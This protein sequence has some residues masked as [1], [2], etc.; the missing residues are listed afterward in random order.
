MIQHDRFREDLLDLDDP[1]AAS[2]GVHIAGPA[3]AARVEDNAVVFT[4]PLFACKPFSFEADPGAAQLTVQLRVQSWDGCMVRAT[5]S[6]GGDGEAEPASLDSSPMIERDPGF[7]P[8]R[9]TVT[10]GA[11]AGEYVVRDASGR[12]AFRTVPPRA[13]SHPWSR[14]LPDPAPVFDAVVVPDARTGVPFMAHDSFFPAHRES[15]GLGCVTRRGRPRLSLFSLH[16]RP[17]ERFLGTGERFSRFGLAGSTVVLENTDALGVSSRRAYKNVPFYV[18][19]AGYGLFIHTSYRTRL[20]FADVSSRAVQGA[21][22]SPVL[23]L[24]F[25]GG[26]VQS[27]VSTYRRL[28]GRPPLPPLWSYGTWMARMTYFSAEEVRGVAEG[29]RRGGFPCDVI[30]LDTGWFR[31]DWRCEWEFSPERFPD[32]EGFLRDMRQKGFRVS[33]WQLPLVTEG[34]SLFSLAREKQ[35]IAPGTQPPLES[36]FDD[37]RGCTIDFT[38]PDAVQW[39]KGLLRRLLTMGAAAIKTDFGETID[40]QASYQGMDAARLRNIYCLLYHRAAFEVTREVYPDGIIWARSGWAGS[41]RYPVHWGGDAAATWDG[42]AATIRGGLQIGLSGFGFWS[43]DVPG[44]HSLPSFMNDRPADDLFVRWTQVGVFTS[45]LRFH[46]SSAREPWEYPAVAEVVRQWL[47]L[48]YALIPYLL[49]EARDSAASGLPIF[50]SLVFHHDDDPIAWTV[51]DEF[52]CGSAFLVAPILS[53]SGVRSVYLPAGQWI[54]FWTGERVRG[55]VMLDRVEQPLERVPLYV[56][57]GSRI[58]FYPEPVAC[59]DEM[60]LSRTSELIFDPRYQ[61]FRASALAAHINL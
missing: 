2:D 46:G 44:F 28:T 34:T 40:M 6:F 45:H 27:I 29:M 18:S 3:T 13:P 30:H 26:S 7:Q 8:G 53:A 24:F 54:D 9:V 22:E 39:Y 41:Q 52:Y 21:V 5:V 61:G 32:P 23:D 43:H 11:A 59:T 56:R 12:A 55:P 4:V 58:P 17:G 10:A 51:E 60:D 14:Q 35:Y 57:S 37:A 33:L 16:A 48:R 19:S 49:R 20:S 15:I 31:T 38:N 36:K 42:L 50:R 1:A 47:R 25:I